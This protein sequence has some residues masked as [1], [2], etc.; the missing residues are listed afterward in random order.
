[1]SLALRE[2]GQHAARFIYAH[3]TLIAKAVGRWTVLFG[4]VVVF[5]K[6]ALELVERGVLPFDAPVMAW[7]ANFHA[8]DLTEA[9]L[10]LTRL[11]G[12]KF[13]MFV[14]VVMAGLMWLAKHPRSA[15]YLASIA[16]GTAA[17]NVGLKLLFARD[18]PDALL[19]LIDTSGYSFPSGHAMASAAIYGAVAVVLF[20]R[21][22][23]IKWPSL[24]VCVALVTAIGLSRVYLRVHY[25]SDVL[26]GWGLGLCWPLWLKPLVLGKKPLAV[27][28][29]ERDAAAIAH[30]AES[31]AHVMP[32]RVEETR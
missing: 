18:R 8:E 16:A 21:F 13:L 12:G 3:G 9:V 17:L 15:I 4:G 24:I 20:T 11:G 30:G 32:H 14:A 19:R 7:F 1:V 26:A 27:E 5:A 10:F 2:R 23:R 31:L 25:P 28:A 22:P 6:L 29:A